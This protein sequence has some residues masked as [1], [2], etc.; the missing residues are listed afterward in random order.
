MG[1]TMRSIRRNQLPLLVCSVNQKLTTKPTKGIHIAVLVLVASATAPKTGGNTAPP[2]TEATMN[3]A[4]RFVCRP[5]PRRERVKMVGKMQ[6]SKN[7][8]SDKVAIPALPSTDI[9]QMM[10]MTIMVMNSHK[11]CLGLRNFI[12]RDAAK[13][14]MANKD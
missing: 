6:D 4:P 1:R 10:K 9:A 2:E 11:T 5:S 14:P 7:R 8:T 13:R 12:A 3:E